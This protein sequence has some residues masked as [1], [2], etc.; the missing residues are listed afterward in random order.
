MTVV[1]WYTAR[2]GTNACVEVGRDPSTGTVYIRSSE[3]PDAGALAFSL[4]EW[5]AFMKGITH[6]EFDAICG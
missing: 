5:D 1:K 6:G 4:E 3:T 2:C